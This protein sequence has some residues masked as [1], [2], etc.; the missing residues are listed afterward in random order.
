MSEDSSGTS[1]TI[2]VSRYRSI[3]VLTGAGISAG[4]G[5]PTYRGAG[6]L[7][8]AESQSIATASGFA[9][10]PMAVW[11]L[12]GPLR[13]RARDARPNAAHL[14]LADLESRHD[15]SI[16]II[17]QNVDALHQRAGSSN[18]IELH[19]NLRFTRCSNFEC[20]LERFADDSAPS[21]LPLCARCHAPLRP[22]VILF[23]EALDGG[24]EWHAK[25]ALRGCD[26]FLAVGTSGSVSPASNFVR[27]AEYAG[28]RTMLVNLTPMEPPNPAFQEQLL[29]RAE[30]L[31]PRLVAG[32]SL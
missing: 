27:S 24:I 18:V 9:S 15:G 4:S 31:L 19:G 5:L 11:G 10:D 25:H 7:W 2:D 20:D 6:G 22:D 32:Q 16:T 30:E 8:N 3:V 13:E 14:A 21:E 29:G 26:L 23:E 1:V 12:L 17:T 28:A